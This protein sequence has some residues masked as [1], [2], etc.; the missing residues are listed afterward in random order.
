MIENLPNGTVFFHERVDH[1]PVAALYAVLDGG[2]RD[3]SPEQCGRTNLMARLIGKG[4]R[5]KNSDQL[6]EAFE[7]LG[8]SFGAQAGQDYVTVGFQSL[9]EDFARGV[10]LFSESLFDANFP[11]NEIDTERGRVLAEI[12]AREDRPS[13][14]AIKNLRKLLYEPHA[15]SRSVEGEADTVQKLT[16]VDLFDV[17]Q[18]LATPPRMVVGVVGAVSRDAARDVILKNFPTVEKPS[19]PRVHAD[20]VLPPRGGRTVVNRKVEQSFIALGHRTMDSRDSDCAAM[21]VATTVLG[22]GMSSRLFTEL[23]DKRGLAYAVGATCSFNALNGSFVAYIGTKPGSQQEAEDG[24]WTE[25]RALRDTPVE[26]GELQRAKN[27]ITGNFLRDLETCRARAAQEAGDIAMG[28]GAG[29]AA[30]WRDE[31][32]AVTSR[33]V[34]RV[35]NRCFLDPCVSIVQPE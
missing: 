13:S 8:I 29:Y 28:L 35:A 1:A 27:Y 4:T 33:D 10:E 23:R 11:W 14:L 22:G 12:R 32:L 16:Q 18:T 21:Q 26:E 34:M 15:Y 6:A 3:D 2:S 20:N 19:A 17:Q 9:A 31:I 5:S 25:V 7:A 24:L 30:K